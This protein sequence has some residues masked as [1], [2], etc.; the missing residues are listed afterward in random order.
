V[1]GMQMACNEQ[2]EQRVSVCKA[3]REAGCEAGCEAETRL[4]RCAARLKAG[5]FD[6]EDA[7]AV[8]DVMASPVIE[9]LRC[10][11]ATFVRRVS[12]A[13]ADDSSAIQW[14]LVGFRRCPRSKPTLDET[15]YGRLYLKMKSASGRT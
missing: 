1:G 5:G 7:Q 15:E 13:R 12:V 14:A 11:C 2:P 9:L 3:G 10:I 8:A 6:T 4:A